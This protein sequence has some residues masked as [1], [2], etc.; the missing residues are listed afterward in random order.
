MPAPHVTQ[1]ANGLHLVVVERHATALVASQ[2]IVRGGTAGLPSEAP[3]VVAMATDVAFHGSAK[4]TEQNVYE[5]MNT[6]LADAGTYATDDALVFRLRA[7]TASFDAGLTLMRDLMV[8]PAFAQNVVDFERQRRVGLMP[9]DGDDAFRVAVRML[10]VAAYGEAHPYTKSAMPAGDA[11][12]NVSRDDLVRVW[13]R[14]VDP[15][16]A[17][18]VVA[19]DVDP[20]ALA[21]R[22]EALFGAWKHDPAHEAPSPVPAASPRR[23]RL[24]VV[25]RPGAPQATIVYGALDAPAASAGHAA[26]DVVNELLGAMPSSVL[27]QTLRDKLGATPFTVSGYSWKRGPGLSFWAG[28]VDRDKAARV[29]EALDSRVR[30]LHSRGA[31]AEELA[32]AKERLARSVPQ[33]FETVGGIANTLAKIP[34]LDLPPDANQTREQRVRALTAADVR[35]AVPAPEAMKAVVVGDLVSI[36]PQLVALGWGEIEERETSGAL[37]RTFTR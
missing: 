32:D 22:V 36:R 23:T 4:R 28:N 17:T 31:S 13:K 12:T 1:L 20:A 8:E 7:T 15:A 9:K 14:A 26:E 16:D 33:A 10:H 19:G 30:E 3:S 24:V 6:L 2:M 18:L 11:I 5:T 37:V 21:V 29:L 35:A 34:S 27:A 25:D